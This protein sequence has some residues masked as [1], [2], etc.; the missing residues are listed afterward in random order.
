MNE[1]P[2]AEGNPSTE[3]VPKQTNDVEERSLR[4]ED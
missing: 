4:I 3:G 2:T 1:T